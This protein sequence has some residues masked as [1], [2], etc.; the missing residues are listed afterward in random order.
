[1][2]C[3]GMPRVRIPWADRVA[4]TTDTGTFGGGG[5]GGGEGGGGVTVGEYSAFFFFF[6]SPKESSIHSYLLPKQ[7]RHITLV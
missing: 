2:S 6:Y 3:A 4:S 5:R 7:F 1:M